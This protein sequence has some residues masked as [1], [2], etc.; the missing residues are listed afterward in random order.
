MS[1]IIDSAPDAHTF[2]IVHPRGVPFNTLIASAASSLNV[3]L[4][5]YPEWLSRLTEAHNSQSF[6]APELERAQEANP[7][8]ALFSF[9]RSAR[10]GPYWEPLGVARLDTARAVRV[11]NILAKDAKPLGEENVRKWMSAWR[12]SGFI[13]PQAEEAAARTETAVS[14]QD[15]AAVALTTL[16]S[17]GQLSASMV[18]KEVGV[19][20]R[21][22]ILVAL[23]SSLYLLY[24]YSYTSTGGVPR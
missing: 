23:L 21:F 7:A 20:S 10:V 4:V 22:G 8:L 15:A 17:T 16:A 19:A 14:K 3:P 13:P 6:S 9:F 24:S 11:S 5:P 1:R 18:I 2:H 12:A